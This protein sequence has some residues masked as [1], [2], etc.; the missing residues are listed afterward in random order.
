VKLIKTRPKIRLTLPEWAHAGD[1]VVAEVIL[2]AKRAVPIR[3]VHCTL[4][5]LQRSSWGGGNQQRTYKAPIIAL[6]AEPCGERE[7][8]KGTSRFRC[9]FDLSDDIPPTYNGSRATIEYIVQVHVSVPWWPDARDRFVLL[10]RPEPQKT[11]GAGR[12][13]HSTQPEG[14][15]GDEPHIEFSLNETRLLPGDTVRGELALANVGYNRYRTAR[16]SLVGKE[17]IATGSGRAVGTLT[18]WRYAIEVDVQKAAEGEPI[19]FAMKLP[20]DVMPTF[21]AVVTKLAWHFEIEVKIAWGK[22]LTAQVPVRLLP[23]ES[24]RATPKSRNA[25]LTVGNPRVKAV[26]QE[27]AEEHGARFDEETSTLVGNVGD[28]S[29]EVSREHRGGDGIFVVAR[30]AYRSLHIAIDGGLA[31]G[32]RRVFDRGF[33]VGDKAWDRRHY[34][35]GREERQ[36]VGFMTALM[37]VLSKL[38]LADISD[39]EL[40]V[41]VR[42]AG[43]ARA[44]LARFVAGAIGVAENVER[45][46]RRIPIPAKMKGTTKSWQALAKRLGGKL[47][48]ARMAVEG[49]YEGAEA[50]VATVWSTEG[51]PLHT[52]IAVAVADA[53]AEKSAFVWSEGR[54]LSGD[55]AELPKRARKLV[56][57]VTAGALSLT[58]DPERIELWDEAPIED[59]AHALKRLDQLLGL[60]AA[61]RGQQG[62][63]R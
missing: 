50:H 39:D 9:S 22:T 33:S 47:E 35:A 14:P 45:A 16:L 34:L 17:T 1:R 30:V 26:W 11:R 63:Y 5:G 3:F 19:P 58:V 43:V 10:V 53:V 2:E 18:P 51:E 29:I 7:L 37:P 54:F 28:V 62:P 56:E 6:R 23:R 44:S 40:V 41:E 46:R 60:A 61:L 21:S 42:H 4:E 20:E 48:K 52:V 32:L 57:L 49:H 55:V 15:A 13:L 12:S 59:T 27:V 25:V 31:T 36:V 24:K 38:R 8:P